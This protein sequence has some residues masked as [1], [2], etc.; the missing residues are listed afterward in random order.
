MNTK[1]KNRGL[2]LKVCPLF[3]FL[4]LIFCFYLYISIVYGSFYL[5][6]VGEGF[7]L[8]GA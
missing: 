1:K 4:C 6:A 2:T 8:G 5:F 7:A 3:F